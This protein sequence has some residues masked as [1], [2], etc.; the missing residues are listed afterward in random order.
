[1]MDRFTGTMPVAEKQGF[2]IARPETYLRA[3]VEGF[4]GAPKSAKTA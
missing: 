1:M 4:C 2:G 3:Q